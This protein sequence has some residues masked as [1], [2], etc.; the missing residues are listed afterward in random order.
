MSEP[1]TNLHVTFDEWNQDYYLQTED[2]V[3][4]GIAYGGNDTG[5]AP[6]IENAYLWAAAPQLRDALFYAMHALED[7]NEGC[8]CECEDCEQCGKPVDECTGTECSRTCQCSSCHYCVTELAYEGAQ[9]AL[10]A[11]TPPEMRKVTSDV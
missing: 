8:F 10:A 11:S 7:A 3:T 2:R 9:R 6:G 5:D 1:S 4:V